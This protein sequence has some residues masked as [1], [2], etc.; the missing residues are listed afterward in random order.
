MKTKT[1]K[2]ALIQLNTHKH[3]KSMTT[4]HTPGEW[5]H[6]GTSA[7]QHLIASEYK[8]DTIAVVY[9]DNEANAQLIATAPDMLSVLIEAVECAC[10]YDTNPALIELFQHVILKAT[11]NK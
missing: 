9:H 4:H 10:V 8:G 6:T 3:C 7:G 11:T 1:K 2:E 5:Y